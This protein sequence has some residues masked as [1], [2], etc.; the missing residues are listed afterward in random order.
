[1]PEFI[2]WSTLTILVDEEQDGEANVI[3]DEEMV[4]EA[5]GFKAAHEA[6]AEENEAGIPDMPLDVEQDM[7]EVVV[8]VDDND[9]AEPMQDWDRDSPYMSVGTIYPNMTEGWQ[10]DSMQYSRSLSL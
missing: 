9:P 5:M 4:Y 7:G 6:A 10:L 8:N 2:D 3:A 1:V